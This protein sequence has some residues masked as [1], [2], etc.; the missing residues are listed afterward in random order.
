MKNILKLSLIL[1]L[2]V[3]F[4]CCS[5]DDDTTDE[6]KVAVN[7]TVKAAIPEAVEMSK[8]EGLE[9]SVTD[10]RTMNTE[11][12]SLNTTGSANIELYKGTYNISI[13]KEFNTKN[14]DDDVV[15]V[16][17]AKLENITITSD[18]QEVNLNLQVFP[19]NT[20]NKSFIFSELFFNGETNGVMMHPD[21]YFVLFN[22]TSDVLYADGL[23]FA[24]TLQYSVLE[25][26]AFFDEFMPERVPITGFF[27]L[28]GT[29]KQYPVNPGEKLVVAWTAINHPAKEGYV[30][31]VDLSGADF[32]VYDPNPDAKDVDNPKVPNVTISGNLPTFF[33]RGFFAPFLFKLEDG[34]QATVEKF[35]ND[36]TSEY[37]YP[38]GSK[39][40]ITSVSASMIVEG[41]VT[42]DRPLVTR[43]LPESVDRGYIT[44]SGCH[45]NELA[46]R[47]EIMV[48]EH[49]FYKDTNNSDN[50]FYIRKGQTAFPE[51]WRNK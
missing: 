8:M 2:G 31:S 29:G 36:N 38:D 49:A 17:S 40:Q 35:Y 10:M 46:I 50:D 45:R 19:K 43:N 5:D 21:Q 14:G 28:P 3:S 25:K 42:G 30:N 12:F 47:H 26:D 13:E 23:C 20:L 37:T 41:V 11:K 44:V 22:P 6:K 24:T 39:E 48:G 9:V 7:L 1:I 51:G 18:G 4:V 33:P 16:Y 15:V 32:E 34:N 27:T